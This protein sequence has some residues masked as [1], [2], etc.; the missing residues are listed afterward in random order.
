MPPVT[1]ERTF[2][3]DSL[4]RD[5]T[6][7]T[8]WAGQAVSEIG[9]ALTGLILPLLAITTLHASTKEVGTMKATAAIA[10][11]LA[12]IP[13]G[14]FV[15]RTGKRS[16]MIACDAARGLV[17]ASVP[18]FALFHALSMTHLYVVA[19]LSG[20]L[21]LVFGIAY[22]AYYPSVVRTEKLPE[23]NSKMASTEAFARVSGPGLA[24]GM[25]SLTGAATAV[26]ADALSFLAS[27]ASL[28]MIRAPE[29]ARA[30]SSRRPPMRTEA[31]EGFRLV[32]ADRVLTATAVTVVASVGCLSMTDAVFV[33]FLVHDLHMST[34]YI[35]VIFAI[36]EAGGLCA[37][38]L[39]SRIIRKVG[40]AR[41]MWV[42]A[43]ASPAGFLCTIATRA[44]AVVLI[45]IFMILS[46]ARFV[47]FD[48]S[49]YSYRQTVSPKDK[50]GKVTATIRLVI[51]VAAAGGAFIGGYLGTLIGARGT[52]ALA[53]ALACLAGVPVIF[54]P[55]RRVR[56]I[57]EL[58]NI[59]QTMG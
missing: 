34:G 43:L 38:I 40:T 6:F 24:G 30:A 27:V 21:G 52:I 8:L 57:T 50:L 12:S 53:T 4:W 10:V 9:S 54:S 3:S 28:L 47:L 39:A 51:N 5:R 55:L 32:V 2:V 59:R 48:V 13:A 31:R 29:P 35:G 49:Q 19:V 16:M 22:H 46:S 37:A 23:A 56:D 42:V 11:M 20:V 26:L 45:G 36:G 33:Y 15:D 44:D 25:I 58:P 1:D 41:I 14:V 7:V 17:L 18:A